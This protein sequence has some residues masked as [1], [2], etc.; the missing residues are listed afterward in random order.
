MVVARA[1]RGSAVAAGF[2]AAIGGLWR[3]HLALRRG[4]LGAQRRLRGGVALAEAVERLQQLGLG[5]RARR[6]LGPE[7]GGEARPEQGG[8]RE[9]GDFTH[10]WA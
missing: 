2:R 4:G 7:D 8:K 9:Q 5:E 3:R 10:S 1:E 6:G